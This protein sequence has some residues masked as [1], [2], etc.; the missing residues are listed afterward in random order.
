MR[1]VD[2]NE[3]SRSER[4]NN[5]YCN[6][7]ATTLNPSLEFSIAKSIAISKTSLDWIGFGALFFYF[8]QFFFSKFRHV[9]NRMISPLSY[10]TNGWNNI[11][12]GQ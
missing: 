7:K 4:F 8:F 1:A 2:V 6:T 5:Y 9:Q 11:G 3:R 10:E 12:Q